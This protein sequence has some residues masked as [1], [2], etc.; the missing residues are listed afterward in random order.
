VWPAI[1]Y[2]VQ[3]EANNTPPLNQPRH[4][5]IQL[6]APNSRKIIITAD[7]ANQNS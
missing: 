2:M 3:R 4:T 7:K 1:Q 6:L 5:P